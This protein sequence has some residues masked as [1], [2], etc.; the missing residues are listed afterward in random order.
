M[1]LLI[2][3]FGVFGKDTVNASW[4]AV[5][6][7][8]DK[9]LGVEIEKICLP[10][11]YERAWTCLKESMDAVQP[12]MVIC[13][14]QAM[15]RSCI[16]PE[17]VGIN[18]MYGKFPDNAGICSDGQRICPEGADGYFATVSPERMVAALQ[19]EKIPAEVSFT[20]GTYVCNCLLYRLLHFLSASHSAVKGGFIHV[21]CLPEQ[22]IPYSQMP[23]MELSVITR[24]LT[25][26][27][28]SQIQ[29]DM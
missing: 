1:K 2:S 25:E 13:V 12:D 17:K 7:L 20:A 10:V 29:K 4:E 24:G 14:G 16:T 3:G 18:W 6:G 15:G 11:E 19:A 28:R 5:Q 27:I 21:P 8:P 22:A 23:S 26:A 9:I